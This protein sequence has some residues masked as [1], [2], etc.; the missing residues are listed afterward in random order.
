MFSSHDDTA[1]RSLD[2]PCRTVCAVRA[3]GTESRFLVGSCAASSSD[4]TNY[5]HAVRF[6]PDRNDVMLDAKLSHSHGSIEAMCSSPDDPTLLCTAHSS[7]SLSLCKIPDDAVTTTNHTENE[8]NDTTMEAHMNELCLVP[9]NGIVADICWG[10]DS[11][12]QGQL[13]FIT[14]SGHLTQ[15]DIPSQQSIRT[16]WFETTTPFRAGWCPRVAWDPHANGTAVAVTTGKRVQLLDWRTDT[17]IP[18]GTVDS[19]V[20]H[21]P[22]V[23]ALDYNPNKPYVLATAGQDALI[24]FWDLRL[25]NQ[26]LLVARGGYVLSYCLLE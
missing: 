4:D 17:S 25:T 5:V 1:E 7:S 3:D 14:R 10:D 12:D 9:T 11:I 19:F 24:K 18:T 15:F 26:P 6:H 16:H 13:L 8:N 22:A 21:R 20:S 23:T 2:L